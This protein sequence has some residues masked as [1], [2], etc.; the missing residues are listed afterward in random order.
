MT[1]FIRVGQ[2][3]IYTSFF[4]IDFLYSKGVN[5]KWR[6]TFN[7]VYFYLLFFDGQGIDIKINDLA[8]C[9]VG[10]IFIRDVSNFNRHIR[11]W[12]FFGSYEHFVDFSAFI[13]GS[14][15]ITYFFGEILSY[16]AIRR[17]GSPLR[18][19]DCGGKGGKIGIFGQLGS[20]GGITNGTAISSTFYSKGERKYILFTA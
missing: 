4:F 5:I 2:Y 19:G 7:K 14:Y 13:F 9:F 12:C 18:E 17:Y 20:D 16:T 11:L 1:I 10:G 8:S 3:Y 15:G 6:A